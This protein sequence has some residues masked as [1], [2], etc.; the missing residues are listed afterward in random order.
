MSEEPRDIF[1]KYM[2]F[3]GIDVGPNMFQGLSPA[4]RKDMD[5]EDLVALLSQTSISEDKIN[6]DSKD[7][8][9]A[10]DFEGVMK[11]FVSRRVPEI[12]ELPTFES[13]KRIT[14]VLA[15][16]MSYLLLHDVCPEYKDEILSTRKF[17][18]KVAPYEI[19]N[20]KEAERWLPGDFNI[21]CSTLFGGYY[22]Q[23]YDGV[24][25]WR[26][27]NDE[28]E[29]AGPAFVG[30]TE[31]VARDVVKFGIAAV[32]SD[33]Q[34]ESWVARANA[35]TVRV[36]SIEEGAFEIIKIIPVTVEDKEWYE[37]ESPGLRPVG[38]VQ[39]RKWRN[40]STNLYEWEEEEQAKYHQSIAPFN[41]NQLCS[42]T[43]DYDYEFF[44]ESPILA[45]LSPSM[46][47]EATIHKLNCGNLMFFD[48]VVKVY[49]S[50]D[51]F[52]PNHLLLEYTK[53]RA[54]GLRAEELA[55]EVAR[56]EWAV[57]QDEIR[58]R[59]EREGEI[60]DDGVQCESECDGKDGKVRPGG[61]DLE[62]NDG[63]GAEIESEEKKRTRNHIDEAVKEKTA[64]E[65]LSSS[66]KNATDEE[67]KI[68]E[69]DDDDDDDDK[70]DDEHTTNIEKD[71]QEL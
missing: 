50:F 62:K 42:Q 5:K 39:A 36:M 56:R 29:D 30:M 41:A 67:T 46:K 38:R 8:T 28:L 19:W 12:W 57:E 69:Y 70:C 6:L 14:D 18:D 63:D 1:Y 59:R 66:T 25:D 16:F 68:D 61:G 37:K 26:D 11:S 7:A 52:L 10:V 22:A 31:D 55:R 34:T 64:E 32:A 2:A 24:T 9:W 23:N 58:A 45:H 20:A 44:L 47:I 27:P 48:T 54:I 13:A 43:P 35:N 51:R 3:G 15:N 65:A 21:A 17:L 4:D 40:P 33:E 71:K 49:N 53:P 60:A